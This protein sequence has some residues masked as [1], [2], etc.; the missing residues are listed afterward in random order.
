[1]NHADCDALAITIAVAAGLCDE[2]PEAEQ[3]HGGEVQRRSGFNCED[4]KM[5]VLLIKTFAALYFGTFHSMSY[6]TR[7]GTDCLAEVDVMRV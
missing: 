6:A 5:T 7:K 3:P 1:M 4:A 2:W